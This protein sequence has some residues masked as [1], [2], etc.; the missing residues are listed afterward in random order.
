ANA[1]SGMAVHDDCKLKFLELKTKRQFRFIVF[2]IEEKIQQV[3]VET[4]GEPDATYDEFT[5]S[6]PANEC[7]YAVLIL[8]SLLM[9]TARKARYSSLHDLDMVDEKGMREASDL[10]VSRSLS[11][12]LR[13]CSDLD[14]VDEKGK[15]EVSGFNKFFSLVFGSLL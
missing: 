1:A 4:V 3:V 15:R 6:L 8:I 7:R 5:A 10:K 12:S 9:R 13:R 11:S 2:R 14:M